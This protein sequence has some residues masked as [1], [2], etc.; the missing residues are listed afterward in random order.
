MTDLIAPPVA[1]GSTRDWVRARPLPSFFIL[2]YALIF[3][4][5]F[6]YLAIPDL[7]YTPIWFVGVFSPTIAAV[8]IS[9]VTG[10]VG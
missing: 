3:V 5:Y 1:T 2:A 10:G 6:T 7:P 8:A 9:W 4:A